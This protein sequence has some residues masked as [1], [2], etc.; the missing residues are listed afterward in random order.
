MGP[1]L[2]FEEEIARDRLAVDPQ[3]QEGVES[4]RM[5]PELDAPG[6]FRPSR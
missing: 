3:T 2:R 4:L 1:V 5:D 6:P